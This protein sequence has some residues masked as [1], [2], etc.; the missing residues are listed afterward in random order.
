MVSG[1]QVQIN[2]TPVSIGQGSWK[3][4]V[5]VKVF[6]LGYVDALDAEYGFVDPALDAI[7]NG[8]AA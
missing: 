7:L 3:L 5:K 1:F 2:P 6:G 8:K 4:I